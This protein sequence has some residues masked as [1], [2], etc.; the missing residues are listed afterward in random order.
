MNAIPHIDSFF[1]NT[2]EE[3]KMVKETVKIMGDENIKVTAT[4][5]RIPTV[6][7]TAKV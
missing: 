7:G 5:V 4:C 3:M 6:G 2:K 1:E